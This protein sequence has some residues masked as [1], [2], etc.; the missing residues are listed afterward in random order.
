MIKLIKI[1]NKI[2]KNFNTFI[3]S[4]K[5]IILEL[6]QNL[7]NIFTGYAISNLVY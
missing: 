1:K 6:E 4:R 2:N 5:C 3:V 7:T